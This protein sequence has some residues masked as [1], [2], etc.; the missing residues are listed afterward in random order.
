MPIENV[1]SILLELSIC[2]YTC[3]SYRELDIFSSAKFSFKLKVVD[4]FPKTRSNMFL[5]WGQ[6]TIGT[7]TLHFCCQ[8]FLESLESNGIALMSSWL[9]VRPGVL[10]RPSTREKVRMVWWSPLRAWAVPELRL[11]K[12]EPGDSTRP[13]KEHTDSRKGD[14]GLPRFFLSP[15]RTQDAAE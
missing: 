7:L 14:I 10:L 9:L 5:G 1:S 11:R 3:H 8:N 2:S 4:T 15:E 12:Q 6:S 13:W